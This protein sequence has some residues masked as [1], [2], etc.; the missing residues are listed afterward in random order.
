MAERI[1]YTIQRTPNAIVGINAGSLTVAFASLRVN[2]LVPL[3]EHYCVV[4]SEQQED[5]PGD[6]VKESK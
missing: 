5:D 2:E 6:K 1:A 3:Y 4:G